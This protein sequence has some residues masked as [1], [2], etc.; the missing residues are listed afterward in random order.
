MFCR[1]IHILLALFATGC[2]LKATGSPGPVATP[3]AKPA[4]VA[5]PIDGPAVVPSVGDGDTAKNQV[6]NMLLD[7]VAKVQTQIAVTQQNQAE[8]AAR[9]GDISSTVTKLSQSQTGAMATGTTYAGGDVRTKMESASTVSASEIGW[10]SA[11]D[12]GE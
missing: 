5:A 12:R 10:C 8:L 1:T 9:L 2:S 11:V 6:A 4:P 7:L 3:P